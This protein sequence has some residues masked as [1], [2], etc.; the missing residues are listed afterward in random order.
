MRILHVAA[1]Y[2]PAFVY[3]GPPR[4][5]HGLCH[6]LHTQGVDI[7]VFT[8]DANGAAAL[9]QH[10]TDARCYDGVP[11]RYFARTWPTVPIG[12]RA[13]TGALR[14]ALQT[15]DLLHIHGLW[16]RVVWAAAREARRAGVPYVLSP[17]GML[18]DAALT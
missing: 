9:P 15:T 17:R 7:E 11:V 14:E 3:G 13:L 5:I 6:A 2:A 12:S 16:N 8:T 1:Y 10:V 18:E 4:S